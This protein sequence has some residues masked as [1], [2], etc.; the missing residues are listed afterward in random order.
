MKNIVKMKIIVQVTL[1]GSHT[2]L[3]IKSKGV[4]LVV[5]FRVKL[6]YIICD[7]LSYYSFYII[8]INNIESIQFWELFLFFCI[9]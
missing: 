7:S 6:A 5:K 1:P 2:E 9:I 8:P 4:A 3:L